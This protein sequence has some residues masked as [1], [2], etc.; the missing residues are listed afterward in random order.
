M[1]LHIGLCGN[2]TWLAIAPR[3]PQGIWRYRTATAC[4]QAVTCR[5]HYAVATVTGVAMRTPIVLASGRSRD[6]P[7]QSGEN[8]G[9]RCAD[10]PA[11][12]CV[13]LRSPST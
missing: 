4:T 9:K 2:R 6:C 8:V 5:R 12:F 1:V 10:S 11:P 3:S 13:G 7:L